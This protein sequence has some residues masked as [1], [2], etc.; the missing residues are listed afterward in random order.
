MWDQLQQAVMKYQSQHSSG[1]DPNSSGDRQDPNDAEGGDPNASAD[2][3]GE[4][5]S[6]GRTDRGPQQGDSHEGRGQESRPEGGPDRDGGRG[7]GGQDGMPSEQELIDM[8]ER[9]GVGR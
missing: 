7:R 1:G 5:D 8:A 6:T 2:D 9:A 3:G 4:G